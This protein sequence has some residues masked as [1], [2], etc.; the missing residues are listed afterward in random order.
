MGVQDNVEE[1]IH[2]FFA[3]DIMLFVSWIRESYSISDVF[4]WVSKLSQ[5]STSTLLNHRW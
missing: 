3:D 2:L 1:V 5:D 4:Q